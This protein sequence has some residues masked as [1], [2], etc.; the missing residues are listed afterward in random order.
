MKRAEP[1]EPDAVSFDRRIGTQRLLRA[2]GQQMASS[3]SNALEVFMLAVP[4]CREKP[5]MR[6]TARR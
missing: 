1:S 6:P 5:N 2:L 3:G 4:S